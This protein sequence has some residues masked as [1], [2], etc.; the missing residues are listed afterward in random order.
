M[1]KVI[2]EKYAEFDNKRKIQ[3]KELAEKEAIEDMKKIEK[4]IKEILKNKKT[5]N[6]IKKD[7]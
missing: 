1:E 6:K 5:T 7:K 2:K 4:E 3:E